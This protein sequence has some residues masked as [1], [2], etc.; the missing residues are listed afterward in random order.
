[1]PTVKCRKASVDK[2]KNVDVAKRRHDKMSTAKR[3]STKGEGSGVRVRMRVNV[4]TFVS[5]D[6]L[7]V[8]ICIWRI[9]LLSH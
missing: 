9:A 4:S 6:I 5:V 8:D 3:M 1:M 2:K 7:L